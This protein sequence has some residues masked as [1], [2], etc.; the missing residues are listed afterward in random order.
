MHVA[1]FHW[2]NFFAFFFLGGVGF[3]VYRGQVFNF[4]VR[5]PRVT[6]PPL[7]STNRS[8]RHTL[9]IAVWFRQF[10]LSDTCRSLWSTVI[11]NTH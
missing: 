11:F 3:H 7:P 6:P 10:E 2:S 9:S 4:P 1:Y 5:D 8:A